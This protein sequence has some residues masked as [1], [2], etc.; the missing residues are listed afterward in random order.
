MTPRG[1]P[2]EVWNAGIIL[3]AIS[4]ALQH[5]VP[6]VRA[7]LVSALFLIRHVQVVGPK[8]ITTS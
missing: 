2:V 6:R 1:M 5:C 8:S 4:C 7:M 3:S